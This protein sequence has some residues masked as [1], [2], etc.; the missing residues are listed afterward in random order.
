MAASYKTTNLYGIFFADDT[1]WV[2]GQNGAILVRRGPATWTPETSGVSNTLRSVF[3]GYS[4]GTFQYF[5]KGRV[6]ACGEDGVILRSDDNGR[7]HWIRQASG[8][9][10]QLNKIVFVDSLKG[11]AFGNNGLILATTDGGDDWRAQS[12]NATENLLSASFIFP[13]PAVD[14]N[15][16]QM[17]MLAQRKHYFQDPI[18][19]TT[20]YD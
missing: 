12:S 4:S 16:Y 17:T 10:T 14:I 18:T 11:W 3:C 2:V 13:A 8:T 15:F 9:T 5:M 19:H 6:F 20:N 1:G 7:T